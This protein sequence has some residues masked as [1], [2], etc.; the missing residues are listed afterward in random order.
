MVV[1]GCI[2]KQRTPESPICIN[3]WMHTKA[4][5]TTGKAAAGNTVRWSLHL[6]NGCATEYFSLVFLIAMQFSL[7]LLFFSYI[8]I[9]IWWKHLLAENAL[10]ETQE[11]FK[12]MA[13]LTSLNPSDTNRYLHISR[14]QKCFN[15]QQV[16]NYSLKNKNKTFGTLWQLEGKQSLTLL[17]LIHFIFSALW[18]TSWDQSILEKFDS[19]LCAWLR[20]AS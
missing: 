20:V 13:G 8:C 3:I 16:E 10:Y 14:L 11:V 19:V 7:R 4:T 18:R 2:D 1:C 6:F 5:F 17:F 9:F 12:V 15:G